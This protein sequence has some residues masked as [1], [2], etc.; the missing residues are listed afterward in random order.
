MEH[1]EKYNKPWA[2]WAFERCRECN[3]FKYLHI[4]EPPTLNN[5]NYSVLSNCSNIY[6]GGGFCS[7]QEWQSPDNL[8]YIEDLAKRKGIIPED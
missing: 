4:A 3:H 1:K 6:T 8:T 2:L 5:D 7:C